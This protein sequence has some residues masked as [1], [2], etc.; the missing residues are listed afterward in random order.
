VVRTFDKF[1]FENCKSFTGLIFKQIF[2]FGTAAWATGGVSPP[3]LSEILQ[4]LPNKEGWGEIRALVR[5]VESVNG[6]IQRLDRAG[7]IR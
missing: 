4:V 1:C 6:L 3:T 5:W 2:I 7:E